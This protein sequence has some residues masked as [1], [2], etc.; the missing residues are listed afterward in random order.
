ML[1]R[2]TAYLRGPE[3]LELGENALPEY[4]SRLRECVR[5]VRMKALE[6]AWIGT[7]ADP[8]LE[9]GTAVGAD[10]RAGKRPP[11]RSLLGGR[12]F[13]IRTELGVLG[14][15]RAPALDPTGGLET[16]DRGDEVW[17][18]EVV[19]GGEGLATGVVGLLLRDGGR[20]ERTAPRYAAK[21]AGRPAELTLDE[22]GIIHPA[23]S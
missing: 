6:P 20:A 15:S 18:G 21:C 11:Y 17:A 4:V 12:P 3:R 7:T 9:R 13:E 10:A 1:L 2:R 23:R 8:E 5:G 19:R 22:G 16:G 14:D